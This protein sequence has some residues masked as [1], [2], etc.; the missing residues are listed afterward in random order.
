[1]QMNACTDRPKSRRR[2]ASLSGRGGIGSED[3]RMRSFTYD[4]VFGDDDSQ[5]LLYN[6]AVR[7]V[8]L[9][10]LEGYNGSIIAYG[11]TGTGKTHTIEGG[12]EADARGVIARAAD[13]IF[14]HIHANASSSQFLVRVSFLQ[15]YN[16]KIHDL[17]QLANESSG[18]ASAAGN[19]HK[20]SNA[21]GVNAGGVG[22]ATL[23]AILNRFLAAG[24]LA[25]CMCVNHV[26]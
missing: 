12:V 8:V 1:M 19:W 20:L 6:T 2:T 5:E 18:G 10:T 23:S 16:E 3:V 7:A 21:L 26:S 24:L 25:V 17:L 22:I 11:Q 14:Q 9:S 13:D 15:I 4:R